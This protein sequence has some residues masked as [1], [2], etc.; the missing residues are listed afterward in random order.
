MRERGKYHILM[1]DYLVI[2]HWLHKLC[3]FVGAFV[4]H[5]VFIHSIRSLLFSCD[6]A[7]AP[8]NMENNFGQH[9]S[10]HNPGPLG[11]DFVSQTGR[12]FQ[13]DLS[14]RNQH[15]SNARN[16]SSFRNQQ[17]PNSRNQ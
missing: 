6:A 16:I 15:D 13:L 11:G 17:Y 8:M 14:S 7:F 12:S 10:K 1:L 2:I 4:C 9:N 3:S 5:P